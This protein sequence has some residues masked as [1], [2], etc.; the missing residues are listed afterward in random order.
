MQDAAGGFG[1]FLAY[2]FIGGLVGA[3]VGGGLLLWYQRKQSRARRSARKLA[4]KK[5]HAWRE[6]KSVTRH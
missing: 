3:L 4:N 5:F 1:W 6:G 2:L